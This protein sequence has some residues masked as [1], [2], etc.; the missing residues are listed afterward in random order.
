VVCNPTLA[1]SSPVFLISAEGKNPDIIEALSR[2]RRNS[3]RAI[4][5][6]TNRADSNLARRAK[7]VTDVD[8]HVYEMSEKDGY[9][10]TNSLLMNAVL[11]A[12]AYHELDNNKT[13][14]P[15]LL[16]DLNLKNMGVADWV[17]SAEAFTVSASARNTLIVL[18]S[19]AFRSVATDLES[20][21]SEAALLNCQLADIRSFAH[22]RHLWLKERAADCSVLALVDP[23]L[24]RLWQYMEALFPPEIP[25]QKMQ[26]ENSGPRDLVAG[27]V[28]QMSLI[29]RIG[30]HLGK[31]PGAPNV[32]DFGRR[33]HYAALD[34]L[35]DVSTEESNH[36]E[37]SK[38]EVLGARWPIATRHGAIR[39]AL[40]SFQASIQS[41]AFKA[42]VFD[43]DGVLCRSQERDAPPSAIIIAHIVRLLDAGIV[44]GIV[45]GR[46]GSLQEQLRHSL[47][48][49]LWPHII[50]G[51]YNGGYIGALSETAKDGETSEYLSH[52]TRIV[53]RLKSLGVPITK[54]KS[55]HPFQVSI[56]FHDGTNANQNWFVIADALRQAGLDVL[57]V[58]RSKHSVDVLGV[59]VSKSHLVA[60]LVQTKR[61]D[62]YEVL[63][64]GDQGA[65]P[66]ND[67]SLLDHRFS[68]SVDE[69]SRLLDRGWKIAPSQKRDV[70]ATIWYLEHINVNAGTFTF[71][72]RA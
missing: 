1:S 43:Y 59:D 42:I 16:N 21:L 65:W 55:N 32:P 14:M 22:G 9:L 24:D 60:H 23:S 29:S 34:K 27:L 67:T 5:V 10:G 68:L 62:P 45:S 20:K 30:Q 35:I 13:E 15:L 48:E 18:F 7:E 64:I 11:I 71:S 37:R 58:V 3:A 40:D 44:V 31:D 56:R 12:R 25:L 50:L 52:V 38:L 41:K 63:T 46:G 49:R 51:L 70:D 17:S 4:H 39:R 54:V 61:I 2:A 47:P 53:N 69:P 36:S 72:P 57:R 6:L 66:G 8:T 28:A 19:P 26:F 33:M